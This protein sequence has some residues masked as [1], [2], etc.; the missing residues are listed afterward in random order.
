[1]VF[2]KVQN[3]FEHKFIKI[4]KWNTPVLTISIDSAYKFESLNSAIE[5]ISKFNLVKTSYVHQIYD[6]S[7]DKL[8]ATCTLVRDN[9]GKFIVGVQLQK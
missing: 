1:M 7:T 5:F 8:L 4:D 3:T 6:C 9:T 2:I